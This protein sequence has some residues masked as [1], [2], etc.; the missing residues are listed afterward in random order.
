MARVTILTVRKALVDY[1]GMSV[2][3]AE[4]LTRKYSAWLMR[5][6]PTTS[7]FGPTAV[8]GLSHIV[9]ANLWAHN[10]SEQMKRR[11]E[12]TDANIR[13]VTSR[14]QKAGMR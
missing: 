10:M 3:G 8:S 5:R 13:R 11:R 1:Y 6:M 9:A 2:T 14:A 7:Y 12:E 4:A